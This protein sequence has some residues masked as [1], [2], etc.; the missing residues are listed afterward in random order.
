MAYLVYQRRKGSDKV[1]AH[2]RTSV[3]EDGT[4]RT[5]YLGYIG[6]LHAPDFRKKL[7]A[8]ERKYGPLNLKHRPRRK[9][10]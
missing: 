6:E 1:Y 10:K 2:V 8:A 4:A 9:R 7:R 5:V 3:W